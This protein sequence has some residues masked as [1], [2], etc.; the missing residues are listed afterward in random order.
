MDYNEIDNENENMDEEIPTAEQAAAWDE[1]CEI[2]EEHPE[3]E[4]TIFGDKNERFFGKNIDTEKLARLVKLR[5]ICK[6]I[7]GM[8]RDVSVTA[9]PFG[10]RSRN[11]AVML[12]LPKEVF[13]TDDKRIVDCFAEL[14][15]LSDDFTTST[16]GDTLRLSFGVHDMWLDYEYDEPAIF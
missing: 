7:T 16:M 5:K 4:D 3:I 2:F 11:G 13:F 12:D 9:R 1:L 8:E 15:R 10:N 14:F 6:Q